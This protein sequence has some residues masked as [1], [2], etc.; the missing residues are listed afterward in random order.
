LKEKRSREGEYRHH[1]LLD[2]E[3]SFTTKAQR[4]RRKEKKLVKPSF[5][6]FLSFVCFAWK[7]HLRIHVRERFSAD[8]LRALRFDRVQHSFGK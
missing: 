3:N 5:P 6:N 2:S 1:V 7:S 8:S 4:S